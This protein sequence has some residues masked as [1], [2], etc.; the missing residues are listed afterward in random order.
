MFS[1]YYEDS[2]I[3]DT[4]CPIQDLPGLGVL[5][6]GQIVDG[7]PQILLKSDFYWFEESEQ[8]WWGADQAGLWDYLQRPGWKKVLFGRTV[9]NQ[10]FGKA[11]ARAM[12]DFGLIVDGE[13]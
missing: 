5:V 8:R 12:R 10:D 1:V 3:T 11:Q 9:S 6:I 7:Q 4:D 13:P 2:V